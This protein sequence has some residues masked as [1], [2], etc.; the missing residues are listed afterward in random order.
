MDAPSILR[1]CFCM[2]TFR[3]FKLATGQNVGHQEE[4]TYELVLL[5]CDYK[6]PPSSAGVWTSVAIALNSSI[7]LLM[8]VSIK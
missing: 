1:C 6:P 5:G 2:K 3:D 8:S 7:V 4:A